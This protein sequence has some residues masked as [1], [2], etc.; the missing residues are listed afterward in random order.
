MVD[1]NVMSYV[2]KY[3]ILVEN[4]LRFNS[5]SFMLMRFDKKYLVL[6]NIYF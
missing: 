4:C 3:L 6:N 2:I 1:M 5:F